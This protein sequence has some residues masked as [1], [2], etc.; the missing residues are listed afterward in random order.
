MAVNDI[1]TIADYSTLRS[2]A[3]S[4][5]GN[6]SA[7]FGYG[8]PIQSVEKIAHEKIIQTDWDLLR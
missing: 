7:T 6:G 4:I 1:I 5:I 3:I 8:Q 2:S